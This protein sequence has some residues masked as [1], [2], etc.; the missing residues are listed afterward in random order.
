[1]VPGKMNSAFS[2]LLIFVAQFFMPRH[3]AQMRLLKA[4]NQI[5][6]TRI[7]TQ[8]IILSPAK[9]S[10]LLRIGAEC[11]H[12]IDGLM[13]V[14]K[15][16][17]Y[18]RW[19]AQMRSGR[20]FKA[21]GRP[22]LTQELRD[23]IIRIGSEN[24]LWG[25]K[26]IVGELKKLGLYAGA[27]SVKRV[28]NEAGMRALFLTAAL[29]FGVTLP[30]NAQ[31]QLFATRAGQAI[32]MDGETGT[33]LYS[34]DPDKLIP[35]ASLAKL[36]TMEVIFHAL[37][38]GRLSL[39]DK[40]VVS[41]NAWRKGGAKS[42]GSTMF[43]NLKSEIRVEDLIK[44]VIIQSANDGCIVLAEGLAGTEENFAKL[45]TERARQ[46]GL[47]QSVF[48]NSSGLP[49]EG[50]VVTMREFVMLA[51]HIWTEYPE[52]YRYYSLREFTWN[53]IKQHNRNPLLAMD[54]GADGMKTGYTEA[55]G[56]AIV[57]SI[58]KDDR[59]MFVA[60]SGMSSDRERAEESRKLLEWGLR[61]FEKT[62]LFSADALIGEA[63]VFGGTQSRVA[64]K[65]G[66]PISVFVP[67]ANAERVVARIVYQG[68][69]VAPVRE[70][71]PVGALRI[72][73][74]DHMSQETPLYAAES[75]ELGSLQQRALSAFSELMIGWLR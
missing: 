40:F 53:K 34:K 12:D 41:E 39:D 59:R 6:R 26:R 47:S 54:I 30:G 56:Y 73:I 51:R 33:V 63:Q 69:L 74:G 60:M 61:A 8:R 45:M 46:I 23:A 3:N 16:A 20:P 71:T 27:N 25:Y 31:S 49:A 29:L 36:M 58:A 37:K 67:L 2:F 13:E 65:A 15:P 52:F 14:A 48:K 28:L 19:L 18:K 42:G 75:V 44:G 43:A 1:M 7:P 17:T 72:T 9:K 50:Q 38:V 21:V 64:L 22:R 68:P 66:R 57:G 35:P 62:D 10:E 55:S 70:G 4:H 11:G 5:L 24:I 32:M